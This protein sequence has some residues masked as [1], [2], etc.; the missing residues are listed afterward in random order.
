[1]RKKKP[2]LSLTVLMVIFGIMVS[3]QFNSLQKP[4]IRDTRDVWELREDLSA[5]KSK[6]LDLLKEIDKYDEMLKKYSNHEDQSKET[7]LTKTLKDLKEKAGFTE[8]TGKGIEVEITQLFSKD[9]TGE[10]VKNIPPDLL[11][12]LINEVNMFGAKHMSINDHRVINTSVIRDINGTTKMDGYSIDGDTVSIKII[13]QQADKL[14]SRLNVSDIGDLFAQ[15]NFSLSISQP[16]DKI[17][18]KAYDGTIQLNELKPLD[19][20]KEGKS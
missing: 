17:H 1:M 19:D 13:S 7:Q 3:I 18:L 11:K 4:K 6:E 14:Y 5:S 20:V 8:V 15:E 9:L 12:K 16:K 2:L 10:E